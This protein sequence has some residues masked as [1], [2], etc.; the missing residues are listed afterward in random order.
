MGW[1]NSW[2]NAPELNGTQFAIVG[3]VDNTHVSVRP[4]STTGSHPAGVAY[5]FIINR[6]QTYLLRN[7]ANTPADL[8][9]TEIISDSPIAVFGGHRAAN[10]QGTTFFSD[11]VVEQQL[12]VALWTPEYCT[13]P[14]MTRLAPGDTIRILGSQN[15]TNLFQNGL[16]IGSVNR[17]EWRDVLTTGG[18]V[19]TGS[20]PILTA[21]F[22]NST[23]ADDVDNSDP[24]QI[25]AQPTNSWLNGYKFSTPVASE[26]GG[27]YCNV[28]ARAADI[29]GVAF[30]PAPAVIGPIVAIN[31]TYSYRR[32]TLAANTTYAAS[33]AG[34]PFGL[35]IYGY[36]A[37]DSYGHSGG[38]GFSDHL[39]PTF[40]QCPPDITI[41][42]T[43]VPGAGERATL[44]N[45]GS[46][47]GITDNCCP[48]QGIIVNQ[49]PPPGTVLPPG[50]YQVVI[51]ATDCAENR[52]TCATMVHVITDPRAAAFPGSFGDPAQEATV[53]G[54]E[55]DPDKDGLSNEDE[56]S[57]GTDMT[58]PSSI[59][60]AFS[61][62]RVMRDGRQVLEI[63]FRRRNNDPSLDYILEGGGD[64]EGWFSGLGHFENISEL[65]DSLAGFNRVTVWSV[66]SGENDRFFV[67]LRFKRN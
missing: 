56:Y 60:D 6:G 39:P 20:K 8:T 66:D 10:I 30:V 59:G 57:T 22:S 29:G 33:A 11:T 55:A 25:N 9:G 5:N 17:G 38:M 36:D 62:R 32:Y 45:L 49:T 18:A 53:W 43:N 61:F 37:Q 48:P 24:F 12:P 21:H 4:K 54:W 34:R 1:G 2:S 7:T 15:S 26:F 16:A 64:S 31:A 44:P 46:Q 14:F 35:E 63:T 3:T 13:A 23:D 28:I 47:F 40:A 19:I 52:I 51:T 41:F 50:N 27:N 42:T 67:R 58:K 65:P